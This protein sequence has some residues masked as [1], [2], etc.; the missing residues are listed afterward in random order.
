[1]VLLFAASVWWFVNLSQGL[2]E[3]GN[4]PTC[5]PGPIDRHPGRVVA[6]CAVGYALLV[7]PAIVALTAALKL[8][9]LACSILALALVLV[10]FFEPLL[11][12]F[13]IIYS[14]GMC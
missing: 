13:Y 10:S 6:A 3:S 1:M 4:D 5:G 2:L 9:S 14:I 12:V 7:L 11:G 8:R